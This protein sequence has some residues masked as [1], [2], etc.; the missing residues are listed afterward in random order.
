[1]SFQNV[2]NRNFQKF[3]YQSFKNYDNNYY[4]NTINVYQFYRFYDNRQ[5]YQSSNQF[6]NVLMFQL[7]ASSIQRLLINL[8]QQSQSI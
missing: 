7:N 1:M 4:Q 6:L 8:S 2:R 5:K 3:R